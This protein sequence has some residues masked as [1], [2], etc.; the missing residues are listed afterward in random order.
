MRK[1]R[2]RDDCRRRGGCSAEATPRTNAVPCARPGIAVQTG[3][4]SKWRGSKPVGW[5]LGPASGTTACI[6]QTWRCAC[7]SP[8]HCWAAAPRYLPWVA[9]Q[10]SVLGPQNRFSGASPQPYYHSA[11][12]CVTVIKFKKPLSP[13]YSSLRR[14]CCARRHVR[15]AP[16]TYRE[17]RG[18]PSSDASCHSPRWIAC[19]STL[20]GHRRAPLVT[21][22]KC[23][24]AVFARAI[25]GRE[26]SQKARVHSDEDMAYP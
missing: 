4:S 9:P 23:G 16:P 24:P 2:R 10:E 21:W 7:N 14:G 11:C 6:S 3:L 25:R 15:V 17:T 18:L 1:S 19:R 13:R 12:V 5:S 8:H 22:R 20:G 26:C